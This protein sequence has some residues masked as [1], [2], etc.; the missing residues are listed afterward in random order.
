MAHLICLNSG[1]LGIPQGSLISIFLKPLIRFLFFLS[2]FIAGYSQAYAY[3]LSGVV[4]G[5]GPP[6]EGANVSVTITGETDP[7]ASAVTDASGAYSFTVTDNTYVLGVLAPAD[8]GYGASVI[9][10]IVIAGSDVI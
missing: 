1:L 7:L 2:L 4:Y 3:T 9:N 6:L 10:D 8:N 5:G